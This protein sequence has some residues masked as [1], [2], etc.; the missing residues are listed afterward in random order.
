MGG[1]NS[2]IG[3]CKPYRGNVEVGGRS[4]ISQNKEASERQ[5]TPQR[6]HREEKRK[7]HP[8]IRQ[9]RKDGAPPQGRAIASASF[10]DVSV[11]LGE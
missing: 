7:T 10:P 3:K 6:D 8:C 4:Q 5:S 11:L 1:G 9:N 2:E